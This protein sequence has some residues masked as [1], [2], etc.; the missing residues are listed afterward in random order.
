MPHWG[1]ASDAFQCMSHFRWR[2]CFPTRAF[3]AGSMTV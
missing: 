2:A 3:Y 1:S